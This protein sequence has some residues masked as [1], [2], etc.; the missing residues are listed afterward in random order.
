MDVE[1]DAQAGEALLVQENFD[2]YW[3]AYVD[4]RRLAIREDQI[5][6]M[7]VE[8]PAGKHTVHMVFETP[9]ELIVGRGIT[10]VTLALAG[11]LFLRR[12]H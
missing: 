5:G 12:R 8:A 1:I 9:R 6:Y 7:L 2:P 4:G 10:I 3:R 11:L